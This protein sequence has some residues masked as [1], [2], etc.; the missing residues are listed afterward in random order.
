MSRHPTSI[1][2]CRL[3]RYPRGLRHFKAVKNRFLPLFISLLLVVSVALPS[4]AQFLP[5]T[6]NINRNIASQDFIPTFNRG[7]I[8]LAPVFLDGK[9]VATIP[10]SIRINNTEEKSGLRGLSQDAALRSYLIHSRLQKY[11]E[12]MDLL[13]RRLAVSE[14]TKDL[15]YLEKRIRQELEV[16]VVESRTTPEVRIKFP[17]NSVPELIFTVTDADTRNVRL[18]SSEPLEIARNAAK[19]IPIV[20]LQAWKDRQIPQL[21]KS[22]RRAAIVMAGL[23]ALNF[24]LA[25][26]TRRLSL[27]RTRLSKLL[28]QQT[29][30]QSVEESSRLADQ[31]RSKTLSMAMSP[32]RNLSIHQR[33]SA[34][35]L[36]GTLLLWARMLM[37]TSGLAYIFSL[38]YFS[39]PLTNLILGVSIR[40]S[41]GGDVR[42][43]WPPMDW[44]LSFGNDAT[45]GLPMLLLLLLM[46]TSVAIS[47]EHLIV[48]IF[49]RRWALSQEEMRTQLRAPT[50]ANVTKE[51]SKALTYLVLAA[52]V[53]YQLHALGAFT[54]AVAIFAGFLSFALS[55]A[56]QNLLK[57]LINGLMILWEDQYAAGDVIIAG[58][59]AGL[60]EK[61]GLRVTK[62]RNLDGE[63]ITIPNG[64]ITVVRNLSSQWSRVNYAIDLN[65]DVDVDRVLAIMGRVANDL[66]QDPNWQPRIL[67]PPEIL[68]IDNIAHTGITIRMLIKTLP[69]KQWEVGRE[70]RRRLKLA[71]DAEGIEVG[72][73]RLELQ[74]AAAS[75]HHTAPVR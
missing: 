57:D 40:G 4:A 44:L 48:D 34:V 1:T 50:I 9:L 29:A 51:W 45:I 17:S 16:K 12:Y 65:Y 8:E 75:A 13:A 23:L 30:S 35:G 71:L 15:R 66:H 62:L 60:V 70:Y 28:D 72:I 33:Y 58:E 5:T 19:E 47:G 53:I 42:S 31:R 56:S 64:W 3:S 63:L 46:M 32:L 61:V 36:Y 11:L 73:P 49:S 6:E 39:R 54:Q 38:F 37:W 41:T 74:N 59:Y 10:G 67:E 24:L 22:A 21:L 20:L 26:F 14:G 25:S 18:E 69:L 2:H 7:N 43:G 55:L 68:G 27:Y 52:V